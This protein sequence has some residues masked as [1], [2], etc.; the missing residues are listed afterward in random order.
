VS[1]PRIPWDAFEKMFGQLGDI[2]G[3]YWAAVFPP[4][5]EKVWAAQF[6]A[7]ADKN[8]P[9]IQRGVPRL[10][11]TTSFG[12]ADAAQPMYIGWLNYWSDATCAFLGFPDADLQASLV[13]HAY[14]TAG[15]AWIV[16][17]TAAPLDMAREADI[18]ALAEAYRQVPRV[19]VREAS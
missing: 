14:R 1:F 13:R 11:L 6:G 17:V 3:A 4:E 8:A 12:A 15:G 2:L 16:K 10:K 9:L 18:E 7:R 5:S 19:G